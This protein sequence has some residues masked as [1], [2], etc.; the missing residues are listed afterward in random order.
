MLLAHG[1]S[2]NTTDSNGE[3]PL[4]AAV[5]YKHKE[6]VK[7][8]MKNGAAVDMKNRQELTPLDIVRRGRRKESAEIAAILQS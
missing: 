8:L 1:A 4:F 6:L 3:T 7:W 2:V 5:K